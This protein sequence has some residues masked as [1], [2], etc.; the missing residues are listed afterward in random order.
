MGKPSGFLE[1]PRVPTPSEDPKRRLKTFDE[2]LRPASEEQLG[3]QAARCMNCGI[4]FCQSDSGCPL[5]NLI[6]EWNDLVYRG[7]WREASERLHATNNFP[8]FTG[9]VCPAP[10]EGACVL[11]L[12]GVPV[13][14]EN[15]EQAIV[16]RAFA[17]GWVVA[18]P[19]RKETGKVVAI[20]G[21]G[22]AGLAAAQQLRRVGH[23]V[24]VF[25]RADRIGGLL[26]Y[27]IPNMKLDKS[28]VKRRV[29][30]LRDE[31]VVFE[32]NVNV[33]GAVLDEIREQHD[34]VLLAT[35]ATKPRDL[36]IPGRELEGIHFAMELLTEST[37]ALAEGRPASLSAEG[38][39]VL[40]IGGGDTGTDCIATTLRQGCA[41][42]T[43]FELMPRPPSERSAENAWPQWPHVF[44]TDYG[45]KEAAAMM[46][47]DP[48]RFAV[49]TK[50]FIEGKGDA[51]GRVVGVETVHVRFEDGVMKEVPGSAA[52]LEVDQ[53]FLAMGFTGPEAIEGVPTNRGR[54][55][56]GRDGLFAAGDCRRG[57]S[58]VVW[59][60]AEGRSVAK[61]IDAYLMGSSDLPAVIRF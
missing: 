22:P 37:A 61:S 59:A 32:T 35:G 18:E 28:L 30:Q 23:E 52:T 38:N 25:E 55:D 50:R 21:S 9:R 17:E 53:V 56:A 19:P 15:L 40:V 33:S 48:R 29:D 16:D 24:T 20:V 14:I 58:L 51:K 1:F 45:H 27:G 54:F 6:P 49:L 34:A 11:G 26:Q 4:P 3:Q 43:A 13:T 60:I 46:G 41:S 44:R 12:E 31:G 42:L 7:L 5:D 47:E 36:P 57:Q 10:C 39:K 2:I 8:E